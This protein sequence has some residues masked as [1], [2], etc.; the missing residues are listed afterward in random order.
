MDD[1]LSML[2]FEINY[3]KNSIAQHYLCFGL[4]LRLLRL[5]VRWTRVA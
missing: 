1:L 4:R 2:I 3:F 5:L